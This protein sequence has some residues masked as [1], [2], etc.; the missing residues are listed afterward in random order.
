MET[1]KHQTL[2]EWFL[3]KMGK[4]RQLNLSIG[5]KEEKTSYP[6]YNVK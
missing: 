3:V 6:I 2:L 4:M 5:E 1:G